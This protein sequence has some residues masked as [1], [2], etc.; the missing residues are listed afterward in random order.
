MRCCRYAA[1]LG[2]L[3]PISVQAA[4]FMGVCIAPEES[5]NTY[6]RDTWKHWVD[7]DDNGIEARDE[8]LIAE[9]LVAVTM[10]A[11][12]KKVESGLWVGPYTGLVSTNPRDFEI[13]HMVPLKEAHESGGHAWSEEKK[14]KY[15]NELSQ[16]DHLIAVKSGSNTSKLDRDPA[17]WMPPNRAYWCNYLEDWTEV[18]RQWGLCMDQTEA[19]YVQRGLQV[20]HKYKFGDSLNGRH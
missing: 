14:E 10:D 7:A 20:C 16:P 2:A 18:K 6:D 13:D 3:L 9:S 19:D 17:E 5:S 8:V 11:D 15:A 1:I 4:G 12:G